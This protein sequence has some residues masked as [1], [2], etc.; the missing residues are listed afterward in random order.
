MKENVMPTNTYLDDIFPLPPFDFSDTSD[1]EP[2][3]ENVNSWG[4]WHEHHN[5]IDWKEVNKNK[6]GLRGE[7]NGMYG[8]THTPEAR[9]KISNGLK[10]KPSGGVT[11]QKGNVPWNKGKFKETD[12]YHTLYMREYRKKKNGSRTN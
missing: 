1:H 11:Y 6:T 4:G 2:F 8:K 10:G 7:L 12:N 9:K 3:K 5:D